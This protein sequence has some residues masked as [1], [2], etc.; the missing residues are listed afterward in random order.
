MTLELV[1]FDVDDTLCDYAGARAQR[2][3]HAFTRALATCSPQ[4]GAEPVDMERLIAESVAM[5]PHGT[6]HFPELLRRYGVEDPDAVAGA[7]EW[8]QTN[9]FLGLQL[10]PDAVTTL[11]HARA[12]GRTIG[13]I[14]NGPADVQCA[15]L[16]LLGLRAHVDF[17][18]ISGEFGIAKPD[19]AIFQEALRLAGACAEDALFIGDSPEFDVAGARASGIRSVWVNR[20]GSPWSHADPPPDHEVTDLTSLYPLLQ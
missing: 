2:L 19:P 5:H 17:A 1:L 14:T 8:Y 13:L 11:G 3:R 4:V 15:K 12:N 18:L 20:T 6:D 7:R 10:F 16:E 9:R